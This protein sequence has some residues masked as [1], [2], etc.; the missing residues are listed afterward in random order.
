MKLRNAAAAIS[1]TVFAM[2][3]AASF[4]AAEKKDVQAIES[5][6]SGGW[7]SAEA[8]ARDSQRHPVAALEFWGLEP[9]MSILEIQP[10]GG[11]WTDILAPYARAN[12]GA[13]YATAAD[14]SDPTLSSNA[15]KGRADFAAK[16]GDEKVYGK[17]NLVNWGEKAA[18]LPANKF[19]FVLVAR[20]MHDWVRRGTAEK[21]LADVFQATKPGGVLAIEQH[22]AKP[23]QDPSVFNGYLDEKYVIS[24]AE[25]AGYK[26]AGKSEINAN[27]KDTKDHP[28]GVWT[29]PP[30]R[31]SS[32]DDKPVDPSFDRAKYDAIGESDRM[33]LRF[34]KPKK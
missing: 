10:G 3:S 20:G 33:T 25:K 30:T 1:L 31:Q 29:L 14:L 5:A 18:P 23:G 32:E 4:A 8:K 28:F 26:L 13:F 34:E 6:V 11:W 9:G 7:R 22:R 15:R 21:N 2:F 17:V 19:D 12:H 24:L 27:P 16:Y